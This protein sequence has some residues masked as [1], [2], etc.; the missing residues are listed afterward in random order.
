MKIV[1]FICTLAYLSFCTPLY[2]RTD[3]AG[4][5]LTISGRIVS[6]Q[7]IF[8]PLK[9]AEI[10][11]LNVD[12][13][14]L[15]ITNTDNK[16]FFKFENL[17]P[18]KRYLI[19]LNETNPGF[20]NK[21]KFALID[22]KAGIIR[23]TGV[24]GVGG[25]F[26]FRDL[27]VNP[28]ALPQ[29]A[30]EEM[31]FAGN[32]LYGENSSKP[33]ANTKVNLLNDKGEILQ[34]TYTNTFGAFVF[35]DFMFDQ[36]SV[37]RVHEDDSPLPG[38]SKVV[39]TGK[40]G[41]EVQTTA[42]ENTGGF[43]FLFSS[44]DKDA[45]RLMAVSSSE[46]LT[47]FNGRFLGNDKA[48]IANSIVNLMDEKGQI[49]RSTKTDKFGDFRFI[50]LPADLNVLLSLDENDPQLKLLKK[51]FLT[52]NKG[53]IVKEII[54]GIHGFKFNILPS[55]KNKLES[56]YVED[57]WLKVLQLKT[58]SAKDNNTVSQNNNI[59]GASQGTNSVTIIENIYY[60]TGESEVSSEGSK[61]FDKLISVMKKDTQLVVEIGSHTDSRSSEEY[62]L[63][64][65][66]R[67]ATAAVDYII[68]NGI[69]SGRISGRGYGENK[70]I[71]KCADGVEC[72]EE[73]HAKNRRTE[74][75]ISR[76]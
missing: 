51:I 34:T 59:G 35:K 21:T 39:L 22:N 16:G 12:G 70:L 7:Y 71:N 73:E 60:K 36:H 33:V 67:R 4:K 32:L 30:P 57:P 45:L 19:E 46:L 38:N 27:P 23:E 58:K 69:A 54:R 15:T 63:N 56:I 41:K 44:F 17:D 66:L 8:N 62:N 9:N 20:P 6:S 65:S 53:A 18:S 14:V 24:D 50:N 76:E 2:A 43:K 64:L 37:L 68:K 5:L 10:A 55:E 13:T 47:D 49:I 74:F 31:K 28:Y 48:P 26:I 11:L 42:T 29:V 52:D 75:K 3:N 72:S 1:F 61:V 40:G 25:K